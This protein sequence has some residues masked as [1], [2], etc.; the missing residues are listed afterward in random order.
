MEIDE[1]GGR[2]P[3]RV[4]GWTTAYVLAIGLPLCHLLLGLDGLIRDG[5]PLVAAAA[6]TGY[7]PRRA[8]LAEPSGDA[9]G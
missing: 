6:L 4:L 8:A 1:G 9:Y 5:A 2:R 7:A 3:R